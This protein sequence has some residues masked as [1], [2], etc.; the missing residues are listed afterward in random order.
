MAELAEAEAEWGASPVQLVRPLVLA[1]CAAPVAG[2]AALAH[3][4]L[5][6]ALLKRS[7]NGLFYILIQ[8]AMA[9]LLLLGTT[10]APE[11]WSYNAGTWQFGRSAC[12]AY[13][14]LNVFA[15]T[16]SLYLIT[17]IALHSLATAS[18]EEKEARKTSGKRDDLDEDDEIRS[19]RHSLVTSDTSTPPRTM[20]VDYRLTNTKIRIAPPVLFVWVLSASLSVPDFV[21]ATTV[22]LDHN[23]VLCTLVDTSHRLNMHSLLAIFNLFLPII[24]M[25]AAAILILIKLKSKKGHSQFDETFPALKLSLCLICTYV[26]LCAPRS[27]VTVYSLYS[28]S[29]VENEY[30]VEQPGYVLTLVNLVSVCLYLVANAVRPLLCIILLPKLRKVFFSGLRNSNVDI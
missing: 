3:C 12:I 22:H 1:V 8:L 25:S 6:A 9:D 10:I 2:A 17:T 23:V 27:I 5:L 11:L 28:T 20:N 16:A 26:V 14:G 4:A 18:L 7:T 24:I 15:T 21:L 30:A 13:R 29:T 19:S